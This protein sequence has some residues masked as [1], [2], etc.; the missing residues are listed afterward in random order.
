MEHDKSLHNL[1][2]NYNDE[3]GIESNSLNTQRA[4]MDESVIKRSE[5]SFVKTELTEAIVKKCNLKTANEGT[6]NKGSKKVKFDE[7]VKIKV[8]ES[9]IKKRVKT[10]QVKNN[11]SPISSVKNKK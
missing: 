6:G 9:P 1:S 2:H 7:S 5:I 11:L 3:H 8:I 10:I 4:F